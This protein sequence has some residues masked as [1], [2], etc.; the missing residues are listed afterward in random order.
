MQIRGN[1]KT[2]AAIA[3][4]GVA[5]GVIANTLYQRSRERVISG[6]VVLITGGSRGL[7]LAL[8]RRFQRE[9]CRVAICARDEAELARAREDLA[10]RNAHVYTVRCDLTRKEEVEQM[11]EDVNRHFGRIDI[12]VNNAGQIQ[13]GPIEAMR[14]EDF[15]DAMNVMFWW[16]V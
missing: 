1:S 2:V 16:V 5:A 10:K 7:G 14:V 8:A 13:V 12:L 15:E 11:I 9:G 3:A 4:T 6:D